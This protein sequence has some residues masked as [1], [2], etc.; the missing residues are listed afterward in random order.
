[1]TIRHSKTLKPFILPATR[2]NHKSEEYS[3][4]VKA[5]MDKL[6][7]HHGFEHARLRDIRPKLIE[8]YP[9]F[10]VVRNPWSRTASRYWFAKKVIEVERKVPPEYADVSSFEHFLEE[11]H[12]WG[13]TE[14]MWHRAIRGWYPQIDYVIDEEGK[15][16]AVCLR[17]EHLREDVCRLFGL[18]KLPERN[19]N[20]TAMVDDSMC[21]YNDKTIQIVADWYKKDI[22]H[23]GFD[24]DTPATR[25]ILNA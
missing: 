25:N 12:K 5:K 2:E 11:R 14:F 21:V 22:D 23:F 17:T 16:N 15:Q 20:V 13:Q 4:A 1:M 7:D 3:N 10:A 9:P 18:E 8:D 19:R 6:G 24:F